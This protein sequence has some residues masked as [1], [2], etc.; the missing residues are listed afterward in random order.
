MSNDHKKGPGAHYSGTNPIP[1]IQKFIK[2]LDADKA[3]RDKRIDQDAQ[4]GGAIDHKEAPKGAKGSKKV[5]TDPVTGNQVEIEDVNKDF[6]HASKD[7]FVSIFFNFSR[8]VV[9]LN[10]PTAIR[11]Q[12]QSPKGYSKLMKV[13][14]FQK[15]S[16][17]LMIIESVLN[18]QP[19]PKYQKER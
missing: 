5:V 7:P 15:K 17:G 4:V 3:D 11:T 9:N 8:S 19:F 18:D 13:I 1:N 6:M 14:Y 2:S 10:M 12:C 16:K